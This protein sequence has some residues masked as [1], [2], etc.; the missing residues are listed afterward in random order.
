M[1]LEKREAWLSSPSTDPTKRPHTTGIQSLDETLATMFVFYWPVLDGS[2]PGLSLMFSN[3]FGT[4]TLS[5]VLVS[6]ESLRKGNRTSSS[7]ASHPTIENLSIPIH[8]LRALIFNV[9]FGLVLPCL[10]VALPE[11]ITGLLFT[12]QSA[13]ALWQLWPF[14]S[15]AVHFIAKQFIPVA[16]RDADPRA[17]WEK[18]RTAFRLVYGLTFAVAAITHVSTWAISLTAAYALPN[19]LTVE[20]VSALHPTNVFL[21]TSPW[22]PIKTD[23]I[24]Q[25]TLWLIQWDQVFA[26]GAMYWWSLDLYRAAHTTQGK[27][28]DWGCLALKSMAFC[29]VSGFTG[30]AVELLWERE[31]MVM[32]AGRPKQKTK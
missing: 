12:R 14:W 8:E 22:L 20:T 7:T 9:V 4:I 28:M 26:A 2:F 24:G 10:A 11:S 32:E 29:V 25:G 16:E 1:V 27:K 5:L 15:T 13:I 19:L 30:A 17:Q 6:L 23:S 21:N 18:T 3:Y 31:E